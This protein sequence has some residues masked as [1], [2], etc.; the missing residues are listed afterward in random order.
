MGKS[1]IFGK[2]SKLNILWQFFKKVHKN[3]S[4]SEDMPE[5][6]NKTLTQN[7]TLELENTLVSRY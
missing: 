5:E 7:K 1:S 4:Y 6:G 2:N 3:V